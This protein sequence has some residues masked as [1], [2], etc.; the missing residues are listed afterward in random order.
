MDESWR[1]DAKNKNELETGQ[2]NGFAFF[3][4]SIL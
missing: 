1:S 2:K 3:Q 4:V